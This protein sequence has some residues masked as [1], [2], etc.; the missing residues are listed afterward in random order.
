VPQALGVLPHTQLACESLDNNLSTSLLHLNRLLLCL[1]YFRV[2][3]L[4]QL[5]FY[6]I[7]VEV[8]MIPLVAAM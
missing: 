6:W 4:R 8:R 2:P 5:A 1:S 7:H 3:P